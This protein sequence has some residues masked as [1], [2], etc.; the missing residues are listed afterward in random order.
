MFDSNDNKG[1]KSPPAEVKDETP[2][3]PFTKR[4]VPLD[5]FHT[6]PMCNG[7]GFVNIVNE[8]DVTDAPPRPKNVINGYPYISPDTPDG[9]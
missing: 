8:T 3:G 2:W 9:V 6:C 1:Y 4:K 7:K 5:D